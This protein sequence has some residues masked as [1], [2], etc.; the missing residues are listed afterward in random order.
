M[1]PEKKI[2]RQK[3]IKR[4]RSKFGLKTKYEIL[5]L[6]TNKYIYAQLIDIASKKTLFA[7]S[8]IELKNELLSKKIKF[9]SVASGKAVGEHLAK[10][11]LENKISDQVSFNR[12]SYNFHGIVRAISEGFDAVR[13]GISQ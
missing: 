11:C 2:K 12:A 7:T 3:A 13:S 5:V 6:K 1:F 4:I 10:K 9:K 8:T